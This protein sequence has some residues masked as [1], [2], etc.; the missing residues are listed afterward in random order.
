MHPWRCEGYA[1]SLHSDRDTA[2]NTALDK[3]AG[4]IVARGQQLKEQPE[5]VWYKGG[6]PYPT[7][8]MIFYLK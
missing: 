5:L 2:E 4:V 1:T 7:I 3:A 6:V 8:N